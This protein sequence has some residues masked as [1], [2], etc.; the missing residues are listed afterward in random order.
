M[1]RKAFER[2]VND[3]LQDLPQLFKDKLANVVVIVED[4]PSDEVLDSLGV[5]EDETLFGLY[6]GVPLTERGHED[7]LYPDR[8]FI[9]QRPIEEECSSEDEIKE[10]VRITVVHELAHFFGFS[11]DDLEAMGYA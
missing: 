8:V 9:F 3:A 2:L 10:Q 1:E 5:P 6:E 7:P 4:D 11:D